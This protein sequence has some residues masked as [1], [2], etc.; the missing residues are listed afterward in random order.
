MLTTHNYRSYGY[1]VKHTTTTFIKTGILNC[2]L[3]DCPYSQHKCSSYPTKFREQEIVD[4][5]DPTYT[6]AT[7]LLHL[8]LEEHDKREDRNIGRARRTEDFIF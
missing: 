4:C 8:R 5:P 6:S 1:R 7:C 3:D 2:T